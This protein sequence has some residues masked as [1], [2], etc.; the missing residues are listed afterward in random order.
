[1]A[2]KEEAYKVALAGKRI[3][4][5]T[6]DNKWH[7]LFTQ[8]DCPKK[9]ES[10]KKE[11]N[12]LLKRQGKI[13]TE[14]KEIKKIKKRLMEEIVPLVD[15]LDQT[16][17][18][19]LEKKV[20][21]NKRLINE[22]NEKLDAYQDEMLDLPKEIDRVNYELMLIT[23]ECCYDKIQEG[24][25]EIEEISNWIAE[26]RVELKERLVYK[27]EKEILNHEL[28]SYMHDIFGADVIELFDMKYNPEENHPRPALKNKRE[29]KKQ[30]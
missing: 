17:N 13:N 22:C 19:A 21:E 23:M 11:L 12:E 20:E 8:V 4:I 1:M 28:Y 7:Q 16:G 24:T 18:V 6:L 14:T 26:I 25:R 2:N 10:L 27:Q 30:E 5:L 3:P 9:I 29:E 15:Q